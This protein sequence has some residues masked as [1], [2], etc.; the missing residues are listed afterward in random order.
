M[1][2]NNTHL[3]VTRLK[4]VRPIGMEVTP[5]SHLAQQQL[6]VGGMDSVTVGSSRLN[7]LGISVSWLRIR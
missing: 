7:Q 3:P 5:A 1:L 4:E 2:L 6:S